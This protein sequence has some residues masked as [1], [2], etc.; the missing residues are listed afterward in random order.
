[1]T[2]A[3]RGATTADGAERAAKA[4]LPPEP[5][6]SLTDVLVQGS[7]VGAVSREVLVGS[8]VLQHAGNG[9]QDEALLRLQARTCQPVNHIKPIW[10]HDGRVHVAVVDQV[11]ND[12]RKEDGS[13]DVLTYCSDPVVLAGLS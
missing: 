1:M 12:L 7:D 2:E 3:L 11:P 4:W 5:A 8:G 6:V 10:G 9:A 13:W